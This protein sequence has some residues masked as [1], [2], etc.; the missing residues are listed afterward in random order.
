MPLAKFSIGP[1]HPSPDQYQTN[2]LLARTNRKHAGSA[3]RNEPN[4]IPLAYAAARRRH[5]AKPTP[6]KAACARP[7]ARPGR[8]LHP[9][10]P[11]EP[12]IGRNPQKTRQFCLSKR[13]QRDPPGLCRRSPAPPLHPRAGN[14]AP[15][16]MPARAAARQPRRPRGLH[17]PH[18]YLTSLPPAPYHGISF[19]INLLGAS[20]EAPA[21]VRMTPVTSAPIRNTTL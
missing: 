1:N 10:I 19:R 21:C 17:R 14:A 7:H 2:P 8:T 12:I 18:P 6:E 13:T 16:P 4:A 20:P 11:N 3:F 5:C 15:G 9:P